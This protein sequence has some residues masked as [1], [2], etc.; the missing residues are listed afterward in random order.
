MLYKKGGYYVDTDVVCVRKYAFDDKEYIIPKQKHYAMSRNIARIKL[1]RI[2]YTIEHNE[3]ITTFVLKAPEGSEP[4][5][6]ASDFCKSKKDEIVSGK[7]L[8]LMESI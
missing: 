5:K 8:S 6:F 4:M 7:I 1:R 2:G 3:Y